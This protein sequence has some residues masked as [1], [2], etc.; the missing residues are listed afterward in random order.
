[1]NQAVPGQTLITTLPVL[2]I[3]PGYQVICISSITA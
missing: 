3:E 1:M 2:D